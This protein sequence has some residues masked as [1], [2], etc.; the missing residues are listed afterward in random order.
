MTHKHTPDADSTHQHAYEVKEFNDA[1]LSG[2]GEVVWQLSN[3]KSSRAM[4]HQNNRNLRPAVKWVSTHRRD[5]GRRR[6]VRLHS[7]FTH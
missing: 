7:P 5:W 3:T 6:C 2:S 4:R 1:E